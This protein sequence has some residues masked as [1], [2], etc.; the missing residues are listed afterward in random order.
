MSVFVTCALVINLSQV[1]YVQGQFL[2][3]LLSKTSDI[4]TVDFSESLKRYGKAGAPYV[5]RVNGNSCL[6]IGG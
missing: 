2:G 6:F 5:K 1:T 4:Y 3:T